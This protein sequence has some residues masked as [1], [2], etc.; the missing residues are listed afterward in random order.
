M[1]D[2]RKYHPIQ[3]RNEPYFEYHWFQSRILRAA[4]VNMTEIL[5]VFLSP[6]IKCGHSILRQNMTACFHKPIRNYHSIWR[7]VEESL[8]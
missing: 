4:L 6:S 3:T 7:V 8:S 2:I 5:E 1:T